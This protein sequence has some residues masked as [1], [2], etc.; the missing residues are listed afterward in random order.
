MKFSDIP[1]HE[2]AKQRMRQMTATD[3][4]PHAILLEGP[5]GIGKMALARAFAQYIHCEHRDPNGDAC[6]KC[7]PCLLH[8]S[9]N[10]IDTTYVYPVVK[11]DG[12]NSAPVSSDFREEWLGYLD[13]RLYMDLQ[14]WAGTFNKKNAQ[15]T[16]YVSES[17]ELLR[18][19]AFTSHVSRYKI[20]IW[21][22][23]ERMNLEAANKLLKLIEEPYDDTLFIMVSDNPREI[24][25]T[26]YSRV[27]RIQLKRLPDETVAQYLS[28]H[29]DISPSDAMAIAHIAEGNV[30][31]AMDAFRQ[32]K[33]TAMFFDLFVRLMRLA[34]QRNVQAL[35]EWSDELAG[36]GREMEIRFYDYAIRLVRENFVFNFN[37]PEIT[38]MTSAEEQF[39]TRFARFI[40][41]SNVERIIETFDK[42]RTDIAGNANGKIVNLDVSI[43]IILLLLP[44]Q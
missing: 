42:A 3:H 24:L 17:S 2:N 35:R 18:T 13:G 40:T 15:P 31:K 23:P 12:M 16:T 44:K 19:L 1:G 5:S 39:S 33:E 6:G 8:Q 38:Y 9:M 25:P 41:E 30:V 4:L 34:Y 28:S 7:Q 21:W 26:I 43:R 36:I 29:F 20:V 10:H 14:A 32:G 27:Q 22:L 37:V 11:T